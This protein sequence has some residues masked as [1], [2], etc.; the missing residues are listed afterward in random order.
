MIAVSIRKLKNGL[1]QGNTDNTYS[2]IFKIQI[3]FIIYSCDI[4]MESV[5]ACY[6]SLH[7][8]CNCSYISKGGESIVN[9]PVS[10]AEK[11]SRQPVSLPS[12]IECEQPSSQFQ[13]S[14]DF[15][16]KM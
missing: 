11:E 4:W 15:G 16:G 5:R 9:Q 2:F 12:F 1:M 13:E 7:G 10:E 8:Y 3:I 6:S 14:V